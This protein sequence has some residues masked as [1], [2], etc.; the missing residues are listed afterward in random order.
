MLL[1]LELVVA[2]GIVI[3][4][5]D[6]DHA[7]VEVVHIA[8]VEADVVVGGVC[9]VVAVA[10]IVAVDA[11]VVVFSQYPLFFSH[12]IYLVLRVVFI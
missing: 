6:F 10:H 4:V 8:V 2:V 1:L 11:A 9:V 5:V 3:Q 12:S 7:A